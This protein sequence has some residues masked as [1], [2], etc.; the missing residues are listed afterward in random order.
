MDFRKK[1]NQR[2]AVA[3]GYILMGTALVVTDILKGFD[4]YFFFSFGFAL[5]LMG[6][7]RLNKYRKI[8]KN[9]H[10]MRKQELAESDE[11]T[12]MMAERARSWSFSLSITGAGIAVIVL[13]VLGYQDA[14]QPFAWYVCG[15]CVLYWICFIIIRKK[16]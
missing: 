12:R 15:M 10:T 11:R 14:A 5:V 1:M 4:N 6:I 7:L 3:V 2:F 8:T 16:Y 13:N 9:D